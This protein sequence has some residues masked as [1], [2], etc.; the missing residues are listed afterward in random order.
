MNRK[1]TLIGLPAIAILVIALTALATAGSAA[2]TQLGVFGTAFT[3]TKAQAAQLSDLASAFA[4]SPDGSIA[5]TAQA[6][7]ARPVQ[8]P[9]GYPNAWIVPATDGVCVAIPDPLG[10]Y[11]TSCS[12]QADL[13]ANGGFVTMLGGAAGTDLAG[14]YLTVVVAP[15]TVASASVE[16]GGV[17]R[18][19]ALRGDAASTIVDTGDAVT[20]GAAEM[21][22]PAGR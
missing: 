16:S 21:Q 20:V 4:K 11:G 18:S 8:L 17:K 22:A 6:G 3:P 13:A 9:S 12:S 1:I 10:G 19:L 7:G 5:L 15:D 14:R 2:T